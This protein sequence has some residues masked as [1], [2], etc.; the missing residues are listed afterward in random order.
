MS[1]E[2]SFKSVKVDSWV[3]GKEAII[4]GD[5]LEHKFTLKVLKPK[6]GKEGMLSLQYHREKEEAWVVYSGKGWI[7]LASEGE[8][9]TRIMKPGDFQTV[10]RGVIHRM[11][12][13]TNDFAVIEPSTPDVHAADK[14]KIKDVVRLHCVFGRECEK[15]KSLDQQTLVERCIQISEEALCLVEEGETP[16]EYN[17]NWVLKQGGGN[18]NS[19]F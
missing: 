19:L 12:G 4:W 11:M 17:L 15:P 10:P 13:L 8:V 9:G 14:S 1:K 2:L 7:L 18:L 16:P 5:K 6:V 3:W